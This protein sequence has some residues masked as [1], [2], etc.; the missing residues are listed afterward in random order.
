MLRLA[1][2]KCTLHKVEIVRE[3][4]GLVTCPYGYTLH[5]DVNDGLGVMARGLEALS[6][7]VQLPRQIGVLSFLATPSRVKPIK[8]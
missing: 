3:P 2:K 6:I 4:R 7:E 5:A 8:P 1:T